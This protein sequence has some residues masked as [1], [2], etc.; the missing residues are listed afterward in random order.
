[1]NIGKGIEIK[2]SGRKFDVRSLKKTGE[3]FK[4]ED[5]LHALA[6][7]KPD[8]EFHIKDFQRELQIAAGIGTIEPVEPFYPEKMLRYVPEHPINLQYPDDFFGKGI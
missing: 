4:M 8:M 7:A 6:T 1:M 5:L 3:P 2:N